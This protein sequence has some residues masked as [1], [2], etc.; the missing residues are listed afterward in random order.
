MQKT[1]FIIVLVIFT[2]SAIAQNKQ[3]KIVFDLNSSDTAAQSGVLRQFNNVLK[4]DPDAQLEVVC[5]GPA[6]Y[7]L[8]QS[9]VFFEDRMKDLKMF[10]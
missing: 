9:K 5:H 8:V 4:A 1:F 2:A 7:M 3:H 6:V 10:I